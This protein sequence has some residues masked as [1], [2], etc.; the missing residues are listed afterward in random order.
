MLHMH[1][2]YFR[3]KFHAFDKKNNFDNCNINGRYI[4][5]C[6]C[7]SDVGF[8]ASQNNINFSPKAVELSAGIQFFQ[9]N[10]CH[11]FDIFLKPISAHL[12]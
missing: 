7:T 5:V 9:V 8:T 11:P 10:V 3:L 12:H 2:N 1:K 4:S 6:T